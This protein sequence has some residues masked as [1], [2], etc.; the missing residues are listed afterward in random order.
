MGDVARLIGHVQQAGVNVFGVLLP[1]KRLAIGHVRI[2]HVHGQ[3]FGFKAEVKTETQFFFAET[4][5]ETE[6][7]KSLPQ[8]LCIEIMTP[9]KRSDESESRFR[10]F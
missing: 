1:C 3:K 4:D 10:L 6:T 2:R 8:R 7:I 9:K 5:T